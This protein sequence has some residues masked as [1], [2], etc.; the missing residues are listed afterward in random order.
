MV[1]VLQRA[2]ACVFNVYNRS[3]LGYS[4]FYL[5]IWNLS[6]KWYNNFYVFANTNQEWT[7]IDMNLRVKINRY[8]YRTNI[9]ILGLVEF[10]YSLYWIHEKPFKARKTQRD[11]DF[12][13]C[14][15]R[16]KTNHSEI[17]KKGTVSIQE[18]RGRGMQSTSTCKV[19][20]GHAWKLSGQ[21]LQQP[22]DWSTG[23]VLQ[24][25]CM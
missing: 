24:T 20:W 12:C 21:S 11:F 7:S 5:W 3:N 14:Y 23:P 2:P 6:F 17:K 15:I 22:T 13:C 19:I 10:F 16:M 1:N 18:E 9:E 4:M 8:E 25:K